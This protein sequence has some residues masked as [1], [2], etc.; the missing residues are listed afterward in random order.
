M[1]I[2]NGILYAGQG[3][4]QLAT[5][6]FQISF[7]KVALCLLFGKYAKGEKSINI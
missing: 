1:K 4:T 5:C 7:L 6:I 2:L 3:S